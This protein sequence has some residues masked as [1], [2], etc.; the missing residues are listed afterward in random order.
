VKINKIAG[1]K[2]I[3]TAWRVSIIELRWFHRSYHR[4]ASRRAL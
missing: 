4:V 1:S 3:E 2:K